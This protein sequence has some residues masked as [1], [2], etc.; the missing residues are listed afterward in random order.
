MIEECL[1]MPAADLERAIEE[2][3]RD[4]RRATVRLLWHLA[5]FE[6][7]ML[8][9]D[10]AYPSMF[11]YCTRKL[12]LSEGAAYRR[13]HAARALSSFPQLADWLGQGR[14]HLSAVTLLSPHLTAEN[15]AGLLA[16]ASGKT[17]RELEFLIAE[18]APKPDI[19]EAIRMQFPDQTAAPTAPA[20]QVSSAA[21]GPAPQPQRPISSIEVIAPRAPGRIRFCFSAGPTVLAKFERAKELLKHKFPAGR[22]EDVIDDALEA[23]LDK[24]DPDRRIARRLLRGTL[25]NG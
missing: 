5:A 19:G 23:L 12:G 10:R 24:R 20:A 16:R 1:R 25:H 18:V 13:I 3:I 21:P 11:V 17:K 14:I 6:Q 22:L 4:E 15:A 8:F 9:A 7:R 2:M